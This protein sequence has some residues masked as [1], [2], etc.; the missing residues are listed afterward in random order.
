MPRGILAVESL[1]DVSLAP[2][3]ARFRAFVAD[4]LA[5]DPPDVDLFVGPRPDPATPQFF[6]PPTSGTAPNGL[7]VYNWDQAAAQLAR[8]GGSWSFSHGASVTVTYAFRSTAPGAM[9]DD[10]GG[11]SRFSAAQ[12]AAAETALQLWSDVANITFLRVGSGSSGEGAYSNNASILFSNYST[13]AEGAAAFAYYP[14]PGATG[15]AQVAGDVW[16][17]VSQPENASPAFGGFGMHT[18]THEIGH[19]IGL[20]HPGDYNAGPGQSPTYEGDAVYWQ[21]T[22]MFTVMSYFGSIN[23]GGSLNAFAAG[24]QLHDIAAAQLL[25]GANMSTRTGDT[26]YGFNSNTGRQHFTITSSTGSPV[27]AIWDAGGNDTLDLSGYATPSEIDLREEAFSGA[28][29]GNGGDGVAHGNIAI[30]RGAVIEN[31]IGGSGADVIIGNAANNAITGNGGADS[32][33][34]LGGVDTSHYA[35]ASSGASWTRTVSGSWTV[36]AGG[37]G[38]DTL[39]S[40]EFLHFSDR[41]VFLDRAAR[42]FSGNGTS[43]VL[44]RRADGVTVSWEVTGASITTTTLLPAA[45]AAW[46]VLGTGD[47][48]GAGRD[49]II[50]RRNDGVVHSR[51][52]NGGFVAAVALPTVGPEWAF[53]GLGDF[54]GDLTDDLAWRRNDGGVYIWRMSASAIQ[55][56]NAVA[57]LGAEWQIAGFGDFNGD[58]RDDFLWRRSDNGQTVVWHMN[59]GIIQSSG[60]TS[61]QV[62]LGWSVAGVG[63]TNGDGRDDILWQRASDGLAAVW[64]MNGATVV[65]GNIAAASPSDWTIHNIGDYNGD[66]RED[67]LWRHDNGLVYVWLLNGTSIIG[68][69]GLAGVGAEWSII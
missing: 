51:T 21:D 50:W 61:A 2:A 34:G 35:L 25:Y 44:F 54:N 41:D 32:I 14:S 57:G 69:G 11:F 64:A 56:V 19:A 24:P 23:V 33:D 47:I 66:G 36:S 30:A 48:S 12:I 3:G 4:P 46:S 40:V 17:N 37:A 20:A 63:D 31:A 49:D 62:G 22:R 28:G 6:M 15:A 42:T 7:P 9:P 67:I 53:L 39:T 45:G 8:D 13:G 58:G 1:S 5:R 43:D 59:G 10:T 38:T 18:L 26:I 16:V 27:F 60:F 55:S 29:P 68:S 65:G 52:M